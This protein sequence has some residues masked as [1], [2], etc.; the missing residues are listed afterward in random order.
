MWVDKVCCSNLRI[1]VPTVAASC[2]QC[3]ETRSELEGII[4]GRVGEVAADMVICPLLE[5]EER[6]D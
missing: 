2:L 6:N 3:L 1:E 4:V 5:V